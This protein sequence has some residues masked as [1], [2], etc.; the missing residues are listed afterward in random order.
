MDNNNRIK[1]YFMKQ[2][3]FN[4]KNN[5]SRVFG[6]FPSFNMK[7][8][9]YIYPIAMILLTVLTLNSCKKTF[10]IEPKDS[11]EASKMYRN[12]KDADAAVL[13]VYS[14]FLGIATQYVVLNELRADLMDVTNSASDYLKEINN[15]SVSSGNPYADPKP[16]YEVI[17]NCN[18]VLKNFTIMR[19]ELKFTQDEYYQRYSDIAALRS[20]IYLQLAIQYGTV[21]YVIQPF[22]KVSD[23]KDESKYPKVELNAMI[24]SLI[25]CM[26]ALPYKEDYPVTATLMG[27][28]S[29]NYTTTPFFINK[30]IL[31]GDLY[32]WKGNYLQ[33]AS[34]YKAVLDVGGAIDFDTYRIEG[35]QVG[36]I[37]TAY[38]DLSINY[39]MRYNWSDIYGLINS[40]TLGWRSIFARP[41]DKLYYNEWLW[42]L[43]FDS[44]TQPN[45]PFVEL[46]ANYGAGK[47]E[48]KPSQQAMDNWNS[49]VQNNGFP[50]DARGQLSYSTSSGQPVI[51]KYLY[52]YDLLYPY[53][54][55][56]RLFLYRT[57]GLH[58]HYMEAANRDNMCKLA[59]ALLN[60]G[61]RHEFS[62]Y[63]D[64]G[65]G[66]DTVA[67]I[68]EIQRT[69]GAVFNYSFPYNFDG[70]Q[71]NE[72]FNYNSRIHSA[73]TGIDTTN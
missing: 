3:Y 18:D 73:K 43:F 41:Q 35:A 68:T 13:G 54:K 4:Q 33:A 62:V 57:A 65:Q 53:K 22:E 12:V 34:N 21:P 61:I 26:Q 66:Q 63:W 47:Y 5:S 30:R 46:F 71:A 24:D 42:Q 31:L 1:L 38:Q 59:L 9:R 29:G 27:I 56:G 19:D 49:Q 69:D 60:T 72:T 39:T 25:N 16:F 52:E 64:D 23:L 6:P 51:M 7:L 44:N 32:L 40:N 45:S 28:S 58:L 67:N 14:K 55:P 2:A 11:I 48:L 15:H 50:Y 8:Y 10:D 36:G 17:L 70:R 37:A 20:W